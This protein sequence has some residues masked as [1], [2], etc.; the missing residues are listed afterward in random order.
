MKLQEQ[1]RILYFLEAFK[2]NLD[3]HED[4]SI[5]PEFLNLFSRKELVEMVLWL[6]KNTD[7]NMLVNKTDLELLEII[8]DDANV[9][10]YVIEQWINKMNNSLKY[11]Q[12]EVHQ[13]F[14]KIQK[15][16]HYLMSKPV[17]YWD[18]YDRSNYHS[19]LSKT[20][21]TKKVFAIFNSDVLKEDVYAVTTKPSYFFDTEDQAK[22]ELSRIESKRGFKKGELVIHQLWVLT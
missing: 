2:V 22:H 21:T 4:D 7:K 16:S 3:S 14:S 15:E 20:G 9:L 1:K 18:E 5:N 10:A 17:E 6:Y 11:T 13:I 19:I 8:N 12:E